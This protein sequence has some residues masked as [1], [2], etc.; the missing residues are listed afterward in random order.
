MFERLSFLKM[1][2]Y[3]YYSILLPESHSINY[4]FLYFTANTLFILHVTD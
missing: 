4:G 3:H 1:Y 2:R